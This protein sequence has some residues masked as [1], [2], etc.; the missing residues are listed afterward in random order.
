MDGN[1]R[2]SEKNNKSI[3]E[4]YSE[5]LN[6]LIEVI[7]I[8]IKKNIQNLSVYALS[9][10]NIKRPNINLIYDL[11]RNK[12]KKLINQLVEEKKVRIRIIGERNNIP[13]DILKIF[14]NAEK[15]PLKNILLNLNIA[16]NYGAD[17]EVI[18]ILKQSLN[19]GYK[20]EEINAEIIRSFMYLKDSPDPDILI[21]TGGFQRL[22]NFLL[23]NLKYTELFF[24][25]TLWPDIN[26][27]EINDILNSYLNIERKY[28]L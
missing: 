2:W 13:N 28:G 11:I 3:T 9:T 19:N 1:Q 10:E 24:T 21:R 25:K 27:N 14:K 5:G 23:L 8:V 26:I 15:I 17:G 22:S 7:D 16:F 18:N 4:G 6:K 12:S 20:S